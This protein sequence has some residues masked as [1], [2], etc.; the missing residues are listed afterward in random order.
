MSKYSYKGDGQMD[1][2]SEAYSS[3][4]RVDNVVVRLD[5][6]P[7]RFAT[8]NREKIFAFWREKPRCHP[9]FYDGQ[10]H[11]MTSWEIRPRV[12]PASR[13]S[14]EHYGEPIGRIPMRK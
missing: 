11:I 7:W 6:S 14:L 2:A 12:K 3:V 5:E 4:T 10:V 1:I 9:H 13:S 8:Q